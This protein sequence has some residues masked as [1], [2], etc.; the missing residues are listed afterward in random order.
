MLVASSVVKEHPALA[1][2]AVVQN[3]VTAR[4][5]AAPTDANS[6]SNGCLLWKLRTEV[7]QFARPL[8]GQ[9]AYEESARQNVLVLFGKITANE[10]G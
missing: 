8:V 6:F 4:P 2:R 7:A 3:P 1:R 10:T 5:Q 9:S